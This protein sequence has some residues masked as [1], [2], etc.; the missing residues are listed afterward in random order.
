MLLFFQKHF[1]NS[2]NKD[3]DINSSIYPSKPMLQFM[4][5]LPLKHSKTFFLYHKNFFIGKK[6]YINE[7]NHQALF[8]S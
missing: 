6:N 1:G 2:V 4:L 3:M 7:S 8:S 5:V